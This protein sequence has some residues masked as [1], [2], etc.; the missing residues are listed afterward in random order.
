MAYTNDWLPSRLPFMR[1]AID[2]TRGKIAAVVASMTI[3]AG[4][5]IQRAGP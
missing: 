1:K 5:G 3:W 4:G 2:S